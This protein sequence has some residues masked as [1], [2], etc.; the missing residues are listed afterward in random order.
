MSPNAGEA[1]GTISAVEH[2]TV[3]AASPP[4]AAAA[5]LGAVAGYIDAVSFS[6]LFEVFPANQSGN[7]VLLGIGLGDTSA[8]AMWRP[9]AAMVGFAIGVLAAVVVRRHPRVPSATRL[10]IGAEIVLLAILALGVGSLLEVAEPLG[11]AGGA[12]LLGLTSIAMGVQTEIIRAHAG[13]TLS[14]TYQTGALTAIAEQLGGAAHPIGADHPARGPVGILATVLVGYVAGAATGARLSSTWGGAMAVPI[15]VL[16]LVL[17]CEP[18]W[19]EPP[20]RR[21]TG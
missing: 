9:A 21:P 16:V 5:V 10:L 14:T 1:L 8:T 7:A 4:L 19:N 20:P 17:V 15:L 6:T 18:W 3:R 13:V 11:G 2:P 12:T